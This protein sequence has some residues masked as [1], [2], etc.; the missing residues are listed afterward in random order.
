[1]K[2]VKETMA[3][4]D[5]VLAKAERKQNL[6]D[7]KSAKIK[8]I[9]WLLGVAISMLPLVALPFKSFLQDGNFFAMLYNLFCDASI[10]FV[11][12]S[13][14]ITSLNDFVTNWA[15]N[16]GRSGLTLLLL[17]SA[18]I[19]YTTTVSAANK[20]TNIV[21]TYDGK[22]CQDNECKQ[23]SHCAYKKNIDFLKSTSG[24]ESIRVLC[25]TIFLMGSHITFRELLSLLAH[26]V[27]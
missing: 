10:L 20:N 3:V 2:N 5:E 9:N 6:D 19:V 7:L 25:N 21:Y 14:T 15:D 11:G 1:M 8:L 18:A 12:I 26:L 16:Y 4:A 17:I 13:F 24:I 23:C 27:T 22:E